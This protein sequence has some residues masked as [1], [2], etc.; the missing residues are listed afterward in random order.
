MDWIVW[1]KIIGMALTALFVGVMVYR[2]V[3]V[4]KEEE[5]DRVHLPD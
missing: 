1:I 4:V 5:D 2:S 3:R